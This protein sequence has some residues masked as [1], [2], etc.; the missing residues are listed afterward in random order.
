MNNSFKGYQTV[1]SYWYDKVPSH[2]KKTKNKYVLNQI[3]NVVGDDW[4]RLTLL[5]LGKSGVKPRDMDGGGKFP[6]SF[7]NY[8]KVEPNQLIFCLLLW[9]KG[10]RR[11]DEGC[12]STLKVSP[13][14]F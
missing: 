13:N 10:G 4:K 8:Q 9:G 2:W 3:K 11:P 14:F 6:E 1:N 12:V 7:E 5:T